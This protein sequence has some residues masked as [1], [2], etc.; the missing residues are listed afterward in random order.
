MSESLKERVREKILRQRGEDGG[1]PLGDAEG[2]NPRLVDLG[3]DLALLDM[4]SDDD[5]VVQQLAAK[6]WVP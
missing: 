4:A 6:Y 2:D 5:A 3:H 1:R